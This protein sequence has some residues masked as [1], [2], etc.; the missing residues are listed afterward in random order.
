MKASLSRAVS[1]TAAVLTLFSLP[2]P[3]TADFGIYYNIEHFSAYADSK[4]GFPSQT[5]RSSDIVAPVLQV[6]SWDR[7]RADGAPYLFLGAVYGDMRA[8]PM[9]FDSRDLSL[10]YADQRYENAYASSAFVVNG[11]RY[12]TFWEG[13]RS[14]GH[15]N[16]YC[17]VFDE[18]YRLRYNVTG[19]GLRDGALADMHEAVLTPEGSVI[20]STY[21][22][23]P[24]NCSSVGG[25]EDA[26]LMD[27]GFQEV[28]A[29][30]NEVLFEWNA[31]SHFDIAESYAPY[32]EA[33]G[34]S[35]DS[36]Y[37]FF[38]INSIEKVRPIAS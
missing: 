14:R 28:D 27:S 23:V 10:V 35:E 5:F 8:G 18:E 22:N 19:K 9:I 26:L 29:E 7:T 30:T 34:V 20:F 33:Y 24:F 36:G 4:G 38:H 17:L 12:L 15:A 21:F 31:S 11:S 1:A 6:N 13:A 32:S 37:D 2:G 16:G 3:V 25:P